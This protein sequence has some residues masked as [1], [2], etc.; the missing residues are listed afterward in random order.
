MSLSV[1]LTMLCGIVIIAVD[2]PG[3][4]LEAL[5]EEAKFNRVAVTLLLV[6]CNIT[7]MLLLVYFIF[8]EEDPESP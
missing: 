2:S 1:L 8:E 7:I 4:A 5:T 6:L 3:V